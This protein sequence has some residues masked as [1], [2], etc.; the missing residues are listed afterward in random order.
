MEPFAPGRCARGPANVGGAL[1]PTAGHAGRR[2]RPVPRD[3]H[4]LPARMP[5]T[6][7]ARFA[8]DGYFVPPATLPPDLLGPLR[9]RFRE[10]AGGRRGGVRHL[11]DGEPL[12][13][14]LAADPAVWGVAAGVSRDDVVA[15]RATLFDK[16]PAANWAVPR[17]RDDRVAVAGRVDDPAWQDWKRAGGVWTARPPRAFLRRVAAV[18]VHL[19]PCGEDDGP[20]VV[21]PW[22]HRDDNTARPPA[23][24]TTPAG[25]LIV[26]SPAVLHGS[27]KALAPDRRR[28]IHIEYAPPTPPGGARWR[29][30]VGRAIDRTNA[31]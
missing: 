5:V 19:D 12:V 24:L 28:V 15:V 18:R 3:P 20:L 22:S 25:G 30:A 8:R 11:L 2:D 4:G 27:G 10:P 23:T 17:H 26:M 16:T 13:R 7:A 31:A 29:H 1:G 14:D 21:A 6:P 9:A